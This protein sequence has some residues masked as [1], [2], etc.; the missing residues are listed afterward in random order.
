L[1]DIVDIVSNQNNFVLLVRRE[2][3]LDTVQHGNIADNLFTWD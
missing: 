2:V 3:N 1:G